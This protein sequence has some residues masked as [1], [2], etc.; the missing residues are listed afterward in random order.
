MLAVNEGFFNAITRVVVK[1]S[2]E[3]PKLEHRFESFMGVCPGTLLE[4][5]FG[6]R[7]SSLEIYARK[8]YGRW[9]LYE[10]LTRIDR[11]VSISGTDSECKECKN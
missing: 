3:S 10:R 6:L 8:F 9:V 11:S 7:G 4:V 2:F 5:H 1:V